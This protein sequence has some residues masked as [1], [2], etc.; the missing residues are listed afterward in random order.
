MEDIGTLETHEILALALK[1]GEIKKKLATRFGVSPSKVYKNC[2]D[3]VHGQGVANWLDYILAICLERKDALLAEYLAEQCRGVFVP[4]PVIRT[5]ELTDEEIR[6]VVSMAIKES[7]EASA[8]L[9]NDYGADGR[10]GD[11]HQARKEIREA[12]QALLRADA[13]CKFLIERAQTRD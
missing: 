2:Q 13:Y 10:I 6:K 3:P 8:Q 9:A 4:L 1:G 11:P 5:R 12:L 7:N